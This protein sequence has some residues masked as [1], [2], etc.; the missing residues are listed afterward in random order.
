M[1]KKKYETNLRLDEGDEI[2]GI[3]T[4]LNRLIVVTK[5]GAFYSISQF[6]LS[7]EVRRLTIENGR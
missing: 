2:V 5:K 6:P 4:H 1:A 7:C 3:E